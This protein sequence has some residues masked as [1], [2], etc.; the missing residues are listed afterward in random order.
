LTITCGNDEY[1]VHKAIICPRSTF[2]AAACNGR[3]QEGKSGI[4][5]LA[6]DDPEAVELMIHYFYYFDY[7][8]QAE[9]QNKLTVE[10]LRQ[11]SSMSPSAT[12]AQHEKA[13]RDR[14]GAFNT[15]APSITVH[16]RVYALGE[17]YDIQGLKHLSL[18]KF[19]KEAKTHWDSDDFITAIVEVYTSTVDGDRGMRDAVVEAIYQHTSVLDKKPMQEV[20]RR[21]DLCFDLMMR[22]RQ[23]VRGLNL[24]QKKSVQYM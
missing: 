16:S 2:F 10:T 9:V 5:V 4:V 12:L 8:T 18:E 24:N 19:K 20:V 1:K 14:F 17:K 13:L 22:F 23:G 7:T 21:L 6:D 11:A 15:M 3:F